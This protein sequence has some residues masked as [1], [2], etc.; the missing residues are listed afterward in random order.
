MQ[1]QGIYLLYLRSDGGNMVPRASLQVSHILY[2]ASVLHFQSKEFFI[3][4]FTTLHYIIHQI[5]NI[6][7]LK[8]PHR[9]SVAWTCT[10][11]LV[12]IISGYMYTVYYERVLYN[13]YAIHWIWYIP[14]R[15]VSLHLTVNI[16]IFITKWANNNHFIGHTNWSIWNEK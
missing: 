14:W 10:Q 15:W 4:P 1:W 16:E 11:E 5:I 9:T 13:I 2:V 3:R 6:S 12:L 7:I 8:I